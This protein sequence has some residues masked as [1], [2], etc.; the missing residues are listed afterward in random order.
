MLLRARGGWCEYWVLVGEGREGGEGER[1]REE[2]EEERK[3]TYNWRHMP[4]GDARFGGVRVSFGGT[5]IIGD[6]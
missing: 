2:E 4:Q 1:E 6:G 5:E 3:E